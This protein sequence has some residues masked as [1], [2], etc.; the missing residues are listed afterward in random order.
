MPTFRRP[1]LAAPLVVALAFAALASPALAVPPAAA[2]KVSDLTFLAGAWVVETGPTR[3]E[4]Q[5]L[6][7]GPDGMVGVG[8]TTD[9]AKGKTVF[10]EYLRIEARPDA[11]VYVAQPKGG[12]ATEFRLVRLEAGTA[13]FENPAH[14]FPKRVV[15]AK[16][17]DGGLTARVEGDAAKPEQA[18]E[19][20]YRPA[21]PCG[22]ARTGAASPAP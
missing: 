21:A 16:R 22:A 6:C 2:A 7:A 12:P 10:F 5:W 4:E 14:D 15:Y 20:R 13:V 9:L 17:A 18:E 11:L 8:R 19:F 3:V 1:A